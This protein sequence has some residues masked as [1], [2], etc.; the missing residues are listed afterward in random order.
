MALY[1]VFV[2]PIRI[3]I[4]TALWSPAYDV[5]DLITWLIYVTDVIIN[6]RTTFVDKYGIEVCDE[7][8]IMRAYVFST[9]FVLDFLSLLNFPTYFVSGL[10][11]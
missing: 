7:K 2:I 5:I 8:K 11:K 6:M 9:R 4:A 3:G 1:S 10:D